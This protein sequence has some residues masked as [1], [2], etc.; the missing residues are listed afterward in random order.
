MLRN[1]ELNHLLEKIFLKSLHHKKFIFF[2]QLHM[3]SGAI[4]KKKKNKCQ[5]V[6]LNF[7]KNLKNNSMIS[8]LLI[9]DFNDSR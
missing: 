5:T 3:L 8:F 6:I 2:T 7:D 4:F 9:F 1:K